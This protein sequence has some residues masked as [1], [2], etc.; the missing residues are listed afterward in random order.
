MLELQGQRVE[1]EGGGKP[2]T[3]AAQLQLLLSGHSLHIQ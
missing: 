3:H 1:G 2:L